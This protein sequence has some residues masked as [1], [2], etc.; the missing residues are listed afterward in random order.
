MLPVQHWQAS[1]PVPESPRLAAP[2]R[3]P[4]HSGLAAG[5]P[6]SALSCI[7]LLVHQERCSFLRQRRMYLTVFSTCKDAQY[8]AG[9]WKAADLVNEEEQI[10]NV[11]PY[12][13]CVELCSKA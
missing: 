8:Q 12:D 5:T 10:S 7:T 2:E 13:A 9:Q 6:A 3:P 1:A 4:G 11:R